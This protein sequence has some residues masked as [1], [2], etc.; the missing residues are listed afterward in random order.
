MAIGALVGGGVLLWCGRLFNQ[1]LVEITLTITA[2]YIAY[3]IAENLFHVSGVVAVV[4]LGLVLASFG[5][6]KISPEVA[7]F[8]HHF[9]QMM[10]HIAN[11]LIFVLVGIIIATRIR[12]DM[13]DWWY[14]LFFLYLAFRVYG[15][16][17]L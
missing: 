13:L 16:W 4:V 3:F 8:L 12:L 2:A 15:L 9:W 14:L 11:T 17:R 10:A 7:D 5:R 1:P 6:T